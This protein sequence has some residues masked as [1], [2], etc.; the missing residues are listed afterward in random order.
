ME[1]PKLRPANFADTFSSNS[2]HLITI[3]ECEEQ[4]E[5]PESS[6][7]SA[8]TTPFG[9]EKKLLVIDDPEKQSRTQRPGVSSD[10]NA[11]NL[12]VLGFI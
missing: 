6:I 1:V 12:C 7:S 10:F 4:L 5:I 2:S 9:T 11:L 3:I 8:L